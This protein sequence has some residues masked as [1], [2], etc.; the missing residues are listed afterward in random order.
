MF[1]YTEPC[2]ADGM[3]NQGPSKTPF[4]SKEVPSN[5]VPVERVEPADNKEDKGLSRVKLPYSVSEQ[6]GKCRKR[7]VNNK[8]KETL[9]F[10]DETLKGKEYG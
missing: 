4:T 10:G 7:K 3:S 8:V 6:F 1:L 5:S 9:D 2:T